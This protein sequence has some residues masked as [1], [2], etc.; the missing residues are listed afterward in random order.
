MEFVLCKNFKQCL[1][2][3]IKN[4]VSTPNLPRLH[5][6]CPNSPQS[7]VPLWAGN[8]VIRPLLCASLPGLHSVGPLERPHQ[9]GCC[10]H[11]PTLPASSAPA[12]TASS[13]HFWP[14]MKKEK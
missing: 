10:P 11:A 5:R 14:L 9:S 12:A 3:K 6:P 13:Q 1:D 8:L 2:I 4:P 7:R